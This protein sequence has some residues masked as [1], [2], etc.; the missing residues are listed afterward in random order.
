LSTL[1]ESTFHAT[2]GPKVLGLDNVLAAVDPERLRLLV[3]FGSLIARAGMHGE[4]DYAVANQW[5]TGRIEEWQRR[6]A[7]CRCLSIEWSIW[8]GVGMG[9]RLGRVD[10]LLRE[11]IT[12][13]T[14][15]QGISTFLDLL[16]HEWPAVAVVVSGRHGPSLTLRVEADGLPLLR[17][18]EKPRVFYPGI[19]L[20]ADAEL[21]PGSDPYLDDHVFRGERLLPAV[22][23]I[24]AMG[25][26]VVALTGDRRPPIFSKVEFRNPVVIPRDASLVIRVAAL[27]HLDGSLDVVLR[28]AETDFQVDHFRARCE[29]VEREDAAI[30]VA[31][32]VPAETANPRISPD[33]DLYGAILFQRGRFRR[34]ESYQ[35]LRARECMAEIAADGGARWFGDYQPTELVLGDPGARDAA[36]HAV[37]ACIPQA[38]LLPVGVERIIPSALSPLEPWRVH[39]RERSREGN[40]FVYDLEIRDREGVVRETWEGLRL[41]LVEGTQ[42]AT[43]W[44]VGLLGPYLERRVEELLPGRGLGVTVLGD[45]GERSA[46]KSDAAI[47]RVVAGGGLVCRRPDGKPEVAGCAQVSVAHVEGLVMSVSGAGPVGCDVERV[48]EHPADRWRELVG[49]SGAALARRVADL[50]DESLSAAATRIWTAGEC[51]KKSGAAPD[52]PLVLESSSADR[53]VVLSS[54]SRRIATYRA[55]VRGFPEALIFAVLVDATP[56]R[57]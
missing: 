43:P 36:I 48:V 13:I 22:I 19:E 44:V 50:G 33:S 25:Q 15:D 8:S 35:H 40:L 51:L 21:S 49:A 52:S 2:L 28:S 10:T 12:P 39:A 17:F 31:L 16:H 53:W 23:G 30:P 29:P 26:A 42:P 37:Q 11:G 45:P 7:R 18:L 32:P 6:H 55:P 5:L 57:V 27:R 9:E 4:T 1:D 41:Q 34:L 46:E 54:G 20:V 38:T 3:G 56:A 24:E 47:R 14:P